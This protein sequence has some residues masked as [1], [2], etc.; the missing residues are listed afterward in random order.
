MSFNIEDEERHNYY[1]EEK[2]F[3]IDSNKNLQTPF[4]QG[5]EKEYRI[6]SF[7]NDTHLEEEN[8]NTNKVMPSNS[9][10]EIIQEENSKNNELKTMNQIFNTIFSS[11]SNQ[12]YFK[13]HQKSNKNNT[14]DKNDVGNNSKINLLLNKTIKF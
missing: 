6:N 14:L 8:E 5:Y 2:L 9:L 13:T 11:S 7:F 3:G 12:K 4:L 1:E 10:K